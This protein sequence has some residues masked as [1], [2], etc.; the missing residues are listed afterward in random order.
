VRDTGGARY[1]FVV[2]LQGGWRIVKATAAEQA[3]L[4]AH[5]FGSRRIQ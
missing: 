3:T 4:G 2:T 5:R 1:Q